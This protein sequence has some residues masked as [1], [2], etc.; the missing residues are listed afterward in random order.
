MSCNDVI[1]VCLWKSTFR[2]W[3]RYLRNKS[4]C[5]PYNFFSNTD[6]AFRS[7]RNHFTYFKLE[8]FEWSFSSSFQFISPSCCAWTILNCIERFSF[9]L[10]FATSKS[11]GMVGK[12]CESVNKHYCLSGNQF[13]CIVS[14]WNSWTCSLIQQQKVEEI[15]LRLIISPDI[16]NLGLYLFDWSTKNETM[17]GFVQSQTE[18]GLVTR[19]PWRLFLWIFINSQQVSI[20]ICLKSPSI[21]ETKHQAPKLSTDKQGRRNSDLDAYSIILD[22]KLCPLLPEKRF[23]FIK[24]N[25]SFSSQT[26]LLRQIVESSRVIMILFFAKVVVY[27]AIQLSLFCL[28]LVGRELKMWGCWKKVNYVFFLP[29]LTWGTQ[30]V[31]KRNPFLE[32]KHLE[33]PHAAQRP[34][35]KQVLDSRAAT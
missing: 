29:D 1:V 28:N 3:E 31:K 26:I 2:G 24:K 10:N 8:S 5:D 25:F 11:N 22:S 33:R 18:A 6:I 15:F 7:Q 35:T 16:F 12:S 23:F 34:W 13:C 21:T 27:K 32:I 4:W 20:E 19:L 9:Q 17:S 30:D 14:I